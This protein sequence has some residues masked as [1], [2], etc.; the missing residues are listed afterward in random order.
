M[1]LRVAA[2]LAAAGLFVLG[3]NSGPRLLWYPAG[4]SRWPAFRPGGLPRGDSLRHA[5]PPA[6][7]RD[8]WAGDRTP[9]SRLAE[10]VAAVGRRAAGT[11]GHR[12]RSRSVWAGLAVPVA[13]HGRTPIGIRTLRDW[14]LEPAAAEEI[15]RRQDAAARLA[16]ALELRQAMILEGCLLA[17]RGGRRERFV[18]WAEGD[19]LAGSAA[20]PAGDRPDADRHNNPDPHS[21]RG[22][23][24][25]GRH[26]LCGDSG[27]GIDQ[28]SADGNLRC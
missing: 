20:G 4:G 21:D 1:N 9:E 10:P 5:T 28:C 25:V 8:Q 2:F 11:R 7:D 13:L 19:P 24:P 18:E 26:L 14:L 15:K 16:P 22:W 3:W 17:D 27:N 6:H 12:R 23:S